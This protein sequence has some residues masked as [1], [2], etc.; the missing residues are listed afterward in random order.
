MVK[1]EAIY[2]TIIDK[3]SSWGALWGVLF[4]LFAF[5][6]LQYN[7]RKFYNRNPNWKS[8]DK[9]LEDIQHKVEA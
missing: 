3:V 5:I 7:Q 6:F 1:I 9:T 4:A 8:F 2:F